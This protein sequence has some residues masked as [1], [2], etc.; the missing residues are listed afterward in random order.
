MAE[1]NRLKEV[2]VQYAISNRDIA[3]LLNKDEAT[4]S[5]W[6]NNHRQPSVE[7]LY[8]IAEFL[9]IDIRDLLHPT[10]WE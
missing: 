4:V 3:N 5:R 1:L 9:R 8:K 6:V 2:F 7:N 10:K